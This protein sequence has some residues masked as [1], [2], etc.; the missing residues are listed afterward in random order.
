MPL[1]GTTPSSLGTCPTQLCHWLAQPLVAW[2]RA[3]L[4]YATGWH[5]PSSL[6]TC[7]TQLCHCISRLLLELHA[8][9]LPT[10]SDVLLIQDTKPGWSPQ[11]KLVLAKTHP[12][13]SVLLPRLAF[14]FPGRWFTDCQGFHKT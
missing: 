11:G 7:P 12:A 2:V 1:V 10:I 8:L 3:P 9:P 13:H 6:G 5:N 4:S 14:S